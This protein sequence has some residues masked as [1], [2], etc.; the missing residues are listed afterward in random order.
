MDH[1]PELVKVLARLRKLRWLSG[2]DLTDFDEASNQAVFVGA[3]G[4][5][6]RRAILRKLRALPEAA[7]RRPTDDELERVIRSVLDPLLPPALDIDVEMTADY[8]YL[9]GEGIAPGNVELHVQI[10][11]K[12]LAPPRARP[13]RRAR[14]R[15]RRGAETDE[16]RKDRVRREE[17]A[18]RSRR[19]RA[20]AKEKKEEETGKPVRV[21]KVGYVSKVM[22]EDGG[23]EL[24]VANPEAKDVLREVDRVW[25]KSIKTGGALARHLNLKGLKPLEGTSF[26]RTMMPRVIRAVERL[27]Q[28]RVLKRLHGT[29]G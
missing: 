3:P 18:E 8:G 23:R 5:A 17:E 19:R 29:T 9:P 25:K 16:Q 28:S 26:Q 13:R 10:P 12:I 4:P 24:W 6:Q 15:A 22:D 27:R 7:A 20:A 21:G 1:R 2:V 11:G 14:A